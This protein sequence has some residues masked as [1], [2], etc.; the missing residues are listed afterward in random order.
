MYCKLHHQSVYIDKCPTPSHHVEFCWKCCFSCNSVLRKALDERRMQGRP[1]FMQDLGVKVWRKETT[2]HFNSVL[3]WCISHF[4]VWRWI[5]YMFPLMCGEYSLPR[6]CGHCQCTGVKFNPPK[7][8]H[9]QK[10]LDVLVAHVQMKQ[11]K[12]KS[13]HDQSPLLQNSSLLAS[14]QNNHFNTSAGTI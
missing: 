7:S 3:K 10:W 8:Y 1:M 14:I 12:N 6:V 9:L 5:H 11:A 13:V 2:G 4:H